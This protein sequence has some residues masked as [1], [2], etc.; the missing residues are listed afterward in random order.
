MKE[1]TPPRE[2]QSAAARVE[3]G[4]AMP[5]DIRPYV[6]SDWESVCLI[7]D[8]AKPD[9]LRGSVETSAILPLDADTEMKGLFRDSKI[10]VA[11]RAG[12]VLGF[13]GTRG[14]FITWLFVHPAHRRQGV[15][16]N[17]LQHVVTRLQGVITL[18]VARPNQPALR[19]Y[20]RLG[21]T[22]EREFAGNFKGREIQAVKLRHERL[23]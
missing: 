13:V 23:A 4:A 5:V 8:L 17:L 9:E 22:I 11:E 2:S 14:N 7:Y 18:N 10:H 20:E 21:F 16:T 19:L 6:A 3:R 12:L 1:P 15:A